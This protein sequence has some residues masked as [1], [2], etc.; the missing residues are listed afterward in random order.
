MV[1]RHDITAAQVEHVFVEIIPKSKIQ[2]STFILNLY[3]SPARIRQRFLTL[4]RRAAD[5]AVSH[6]LLLGGD[7]N[8]LHVAWGYAYSRAKGKALWQDIQE[9]GLTLITDPSSPTRMGTG[10][11]RD[12]TPDLTLVKNTRGSS[13]KKHVR[14]PW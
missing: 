7:F 8:A 4:F 6:P 11:A 12:T 13:W 3:S 14:R 9:T 2:S 5:L 10:L 1:V